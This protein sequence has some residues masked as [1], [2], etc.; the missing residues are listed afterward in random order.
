MKIL[1]SSN[2]FVLYA[3]RN[4]YLWYAI[5]AKICP[6]SFQEKSLFA[7]QKISA[8]FSNVTDGGGAVKG[9]L[10]INITINTYVKNE[11]DS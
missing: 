7:K 1:L 11:I 9:L 10:I 2:I 8:S 5:I 4:L 6:V 3:F